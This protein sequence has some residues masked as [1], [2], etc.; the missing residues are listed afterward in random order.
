M[1]C[2]HMYTYTYTSVYKHVYID[3]DAHVERKYAE[4]RVHWK[5][6]SRRDETNNKHAKIIYSREDLKIGARILTQ[7][8]ID[9]TLISF[10]SA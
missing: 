3:F 10:M 1:V 7:C 9:S 8:L 5:H 2:K 6:A 4:V